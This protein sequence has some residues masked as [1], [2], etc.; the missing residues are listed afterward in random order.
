MK[1]VLAA[2]GALL[3]AMLSTPA[4][5]FEVGDSVGEVLEST[6]TPTWSSPGKIT[7]LDQLGDTVGTIVTMPKYP[8]PTWAQ[9][10]SVR[11]DL[12]ANMMTE[13][14]IK[15]GGIMGKK[16]DGSKICF[17]PRRGGH[18]KIIIK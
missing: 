14:V 4:A 10:Q 1:Y 7:G 3:L 8:L 11:C 18:R 12:R 16:S 15:N 5:A 17:S 13:R 2:L 6:R 9:P